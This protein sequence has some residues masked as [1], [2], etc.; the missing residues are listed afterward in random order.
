MDKENIVSD[1]MRI[2]NFDQ[3]EKILYRKR[4][5]YSRSV[6]L[7]KYIFYEI[8]SVI[9]VLRTLSIKCDDENI[10]KINYKD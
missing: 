9:A 5:R 8:S 4:Y 1:E 2:L 10:I 7:M 3:V 6:H